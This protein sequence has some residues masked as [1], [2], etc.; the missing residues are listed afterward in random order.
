[1][2]EVFLAYDQDLR[3]RLAMKTTRPRSSKDNL[4]RFFS[5][6]Q[7]V[8]QLSHPNIVALYELG[9]TTGRRPYYTMPLVQGQTLTEILRGLLRGEPEIQQEFSLTRLVQI[10]LQLTLALDYAHAKGV[11]HCDIKP[12]NIM[13]GEHGE[14]LLLD[15]GVAK[16]LREGS[17][18]TDLAELMEKMQ[19]MGTPMYMAPEQASGRPVDGRTDIYALGVVLY[20]LLTMI[21][22]FNGDMSE[23]LDAHQNTEP[24]PPRTRAPEQ[25]IPA[26]L[27]KACLKALR[28][29]PEDRH[30][31]ARELHDEI[32]AWLE[33][34]SD[35]AK[36]IERAGKLAMQ[37]RET[38]DEYTKLK[39]QITLLE[40]KTRRLRQGF[41]GWQSVEE[42]ATLFAAEDE[43]EKSRR[44]LVQAAS[45]I[46]MTLSAA[47][48]QH[49]EHPLARQTMADYYWDRFVEAEASGQ[50]ERRD[51]FGKLVEAFHDGFYEQQL[52]GDG[53]LKLHSNPEG[54]EVVLYELVEEGLR[55][56]PKNPREL[57]KT[58]IGSTKLPMGSYLAVFRA[59][60]FQ[61]VRV[62]IW[63]SRNRDWWGRVHLY[64]PEQVGDG[65]C[66]VPAGPFV[67]GGDEE[68]KGWCLPRSE[69]VLEDFFIAK[70]PVT[71]GEYLESSERFFEE[72]SEGNFRSYAAT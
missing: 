30:Q 21:P 41:K 55:L 16:V 70:Q 13:L 64:S 66:Y 69:P 5:E 46:V 28:K 8:G 56:V 15:W 60:D 40:D 48:G 50:L 7:V 68:A 14:V 51:Y 65:Y 49:E 62:P 2:G 43:L 9:M 63:I 45:D 17:I 29:K 35:K 61:D 52:K 71:F 1:M 25:Y 44:S 3:R 23:I 19:T 18:E 32:Q 22:P 53:A 11:I 31:T 33:A 42:K 47:L 10:F 37:G 6:A 27:E 12:S 26:A 20:E 34:A 57:G 59:K 72:R 38:L 54:A 67:V 39:E 58:P 4:V 24:I 36:R